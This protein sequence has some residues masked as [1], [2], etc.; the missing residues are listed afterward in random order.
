LYLA[1]NLKITP[2]KK[3]APRVPARLAACHRK[4]SEA[5]SPSTIPS[6]AGGW[7]SS[8]ALVFS[9]DAVVLSDRQDADVHF[10]AKAAEG[11]LPGTA[12][13]ILLCSGKNL[14][15]TNEQPACYAVR[16][17]SVAAARARATN[18]TPTVI[19]M[20]RPKWAEPVPPRATRA[21][22]S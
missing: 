19:A 15:H 14:G 7:T 1:F 12:V 8:D 21:R 4:F 22:A 16:R 5:R 9:H 18:V 10:A 3:I 2:D 20:S 13:R 11:R 6:G 17:L